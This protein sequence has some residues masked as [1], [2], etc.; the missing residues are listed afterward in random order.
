MEVPLPGLT[1]IHGSLQRLQAFLNAPNEV[2]RLHFYMALSTLYYVSSTNGRKVPIGLGVGMDNTTRHTN[3]AGQG[4][5]WATE[6]KQE[7]PV[8]LTRQRTKP[9]GA[10]GMVVLESCRLVKAGR[11][12]CE[13]CT[14]APACVSFEQHARPK[15]GMCCSCIFHARAKCMRLSRSNS[16]QT[17]HRLQPTLGGLQPSCGSAGQWQH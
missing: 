10:G 6:Q 14:N 13:A 2:L 9:H 3:K 5:I 1:P 15:Q 4:G 12:G 16:G 11:C 8:V 7:S 17:L